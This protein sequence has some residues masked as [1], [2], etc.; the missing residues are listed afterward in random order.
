MHSFPLT[1]C[2]LAPARFLPGFG[3]G[4]I[5]SLTLT[6]GSLLLGLAALLCFSSSVSGAPAAAQPAVAATTTKPMQTFVIMRRSGWNSPAELS[7][8]AAR[9]SA[10]GLNQMADQ[11]RWIRSYVT[12]EGNGRVGTVCVYEAVDE[13]AVREHARRA[14]L[15]CDVVVPVGNTVVVN[16]DPVPAS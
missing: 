5:R 16:P 12:D 14:N 11:V 3:S 4:R 6:L 8:A 9:S 10:V 13:A 7:E 2:T 1:T 15:P